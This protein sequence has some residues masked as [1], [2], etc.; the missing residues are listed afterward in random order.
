[1]DP[2]GLPGGAAAHRHRSHRSRPRARAGARRRKSRPRP[3]PL[4]SRPSALRPDNVAHDHAAI[5]GRRLGTPAR[6]LR[7]HRR[8]GSRHAD[9][10]RPDL[11]RRRSPLRPLPTGATREPGYHRSLDVRLDFTDP[12]QRIAGERTLHL[13]DA[14][15]DPTN[16]R[17]ALY[18]EAAR[19]GGPAPRTAF[20]TLAI[21]GENWGVYTNVQPFDD[22]LLRENFGTAAGARWIVPAGGGLTYLGDDPQP[23]RAIYRLQTPESPEAW[24]A[25]IALCKTIAETPPEYLNKKLPRSST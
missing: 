23:Y 21:N 3:R 22:A 4:L 24:R 9:G 19:D 6:A 11:R 10:R 16:L 2:A 12:G 13:V 18:F 15:D 17:T 5:R 25:L 14:H 7:S 20:V 8:L 1:M